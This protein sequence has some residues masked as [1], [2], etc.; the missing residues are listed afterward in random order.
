MVRHARPEDADA[1]SA[2]YAHMVGDG[3]ASLED[4]PARARTRWRCGWPRSRRTH[5]WL[6]A[7][8]DGEVAGYAYASRTTPRRLP[9]GHRRDRVR[10]LGATSAGGWAA[11]ST[12][13]LFELL[14]RAGRARW[15]APGVDAPERG[16]RGAA[17]G[18]RLR[19]RGRVPRGR[20]GSSAHWHDVGWWQLAAAA[21]GPRP[22]PSRGR[23]VV[24]VDCR[25]V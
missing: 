6:V 18:A 24:R 5:P 16:E 1:C 10:G 15:P 7:E 8:R 19:A 25:R 9:L 3:V 20:A 4:G 2:I 17:R 11:S 13:E 21:A 12:S 22:R 23:A 14:R